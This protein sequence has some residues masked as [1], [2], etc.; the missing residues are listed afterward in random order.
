M[1]RDRDE[2]IVGFGRARIP[3]ASA[4]PDPVG[5]INSVAT[6]DMLICRR[7]EFVHPTGS[8]TSTAA[9]PKAASGHGIAAFTRMHIPSPSAQSR[10]RSDR[11]GPLTRRDS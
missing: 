1:R 3:R 10:A 8:R 7:I 4:A 2:T 6:P 9:R 5:C 11:Q